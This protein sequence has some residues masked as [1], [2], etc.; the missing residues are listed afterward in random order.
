MTSPIIRAI[1]SLIADQ[2]RRHAWLFEAG[3]KLRRE[4]DEQHR[5][6]AHANNVPVNGQ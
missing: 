5:E 1:D 6:T 3:E 2:E 4:N